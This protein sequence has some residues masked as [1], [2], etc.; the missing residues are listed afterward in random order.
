MT[1]PSTKDEL[2]NGKPT[3]QEFR[4]LPRNPVY[5]MLDGLK[6]FHNVGTILRLADALLVTKVF[7]CGDTVNPFGKKTRKGSRGAE[8]WVEWEQRDDT[9]TVIYEL[10]EQGVSIVSAEIAAESMDYRDY[11]LQLPVC[12]V[13]G[14]EDIGVSPEVLSLSDSIVHLP[15]FGMTNS[16]NVS[17][18]AAVLLYEVVRRAEV[19]ASNEL[20]TSDVLVISGS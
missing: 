4:G 15:I 17:T 8:R 12:F 11:D 3:R 7:L 5:L 10:K 13:L 18:V 6:C 14:R 2:R 19:R 1:R 20:R 16:L 9:V